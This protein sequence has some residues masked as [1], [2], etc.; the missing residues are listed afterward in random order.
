MLCAKECQ[1]LFVLL[2]EKSRA[3]IVRQAWNG[4]D[5]CRLEKNLGH[6]SA[7]GERWQ[8]RRM[9]LWCPIVVIMG[10]D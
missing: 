3:T 7:A 1:C 2:W 9:R 10:R 8:L 5:W 4:E 6:A